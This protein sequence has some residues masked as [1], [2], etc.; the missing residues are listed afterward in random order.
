MDKIDSDLERLFEDYQKVMHKN[1][2]QG[3]VE[4]IFSNLKNV[5]GDDEE[6]ITNLDEEIVS[7]KESEEKKE[8]IDA[9]STFAK[10]N[11]SIK[12]ELVVPDA[13]NQP[14]PQS[15]RTTRRDA[16]KMK[17]R[18]R[19]GRGND[20]VISTQK[21]NAIKLM[22]VKLESKI[23]DINGRL[24][25]KENYDQIIANATDELSE[26][27]GDNKVKVG[28]FNLEFMGIKQLVGRQQLS[29]LK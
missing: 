16:S 1:N 21:L 27:L 26:T 20:G 2:S 13:S 22:F 8:P 18:S 24:Q 7:E 5:F 28:L 3:K 12:G 10:E 14:H 11:N 19:L 23:E 17:S 6:G 25:E 29:L 4:Q 9:K 15:S